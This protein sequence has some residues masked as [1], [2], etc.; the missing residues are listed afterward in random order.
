MDQCYKK[1]I[2]LLSIK[3]EKTQVA[4]TANFKQVYHL[5]AVASL[6]PP[7]S[8]FAVFSLLFEVELDLLRW[9]KTSGKGIQ[10]IGNC[11]VGV[12]DTVYLC[13]NR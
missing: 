10:I 13:F 8:A 11:N 6:H 7:Q 9:L 3:K 4:E 1:A 5:R 2:Y 12:C